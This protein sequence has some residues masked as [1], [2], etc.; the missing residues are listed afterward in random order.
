MSRNPDISELDL[1]TH[2]SRFIRRKNFV[3]VLLNTVKFFSSK[4]SLL[5][6]FLTDFCQF[7][8]CGNLFD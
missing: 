4:Y 8:K 5:F 7:L 2:F 6:N 3:V 1:E